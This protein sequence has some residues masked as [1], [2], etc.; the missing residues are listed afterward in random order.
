MDHAGHDMD[1]DHMA[2]EEAEIVRL[3]SVP[4]PE[5][6]PEGDELSDAVVRGRRDDLRLVR[7]GHREDA[8][9]DARRHFERGEP[10][11]RA[12]RRH[13][14]PAI[15]TAE[16]IVEIVEKLGY[17]ATPLEAAAPAAQAGKVTL[18]LTG[19]HCASCS[20]LIEKTLNKVPGVRAPR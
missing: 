20:G 10:R 14:R 7:G 9:Q 18:V 16:K 1:P 8:R 15:I 2:A 17:T 5:P 4:D 12:A 13:V 6:V 3:E 11:H 19:M